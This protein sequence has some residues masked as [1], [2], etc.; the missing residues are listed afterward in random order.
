MEAKFDILSAASIFEGVEKED[1]KKAVACLS[2]GEKTFAGN[3]YVLRADERVDSLGIVLDGC[4]KVIK[5]DYWGNRDI[6][7]KMGRGQIFAETYA[8]IPE[9]KLDV[10][11]VAETES[12]ILFLDVGKI[13]SPCSKVCG[14]HERIIQNLISVMARKNLYMNEKL[15]HVTMRTTRGKLLSYLSGA[16]KGQDDPFE[17]PFDRQELADYLSVDR[18]AMS[19]ELCAMRDD[20]IIEF[21]KNRFKLM[22]K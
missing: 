5:E 4:V 11:V 17:I 13:L 3:T 19:K 18:S 10:S 22:R 2:A 16:S 14:Y 8:C 21:K 15:T 1:L 20:G 12:T 9:I 6:M 7:G